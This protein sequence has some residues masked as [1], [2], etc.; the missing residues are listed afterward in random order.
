MK[1][2]STDI[3][4]NSP[5]FEGGVAEGRGGY[6]SNSGSTKRFP[7]GD[8][9]LKNRQYLRSRRKTLRSNLTPAEATL[10]SA[11]KK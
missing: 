6:S 8:D 3:S 5:S 7:T 2:S 9:K 1:K 10:W 4:E 11:I